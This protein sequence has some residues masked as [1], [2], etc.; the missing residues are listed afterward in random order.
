M[1]LIIFS[2]DTLVML[3][4][5]RI[6]DP[7]INPAL[8]SCVDA[9]LLT[10]LTAPFIWWFAVRPIQ[11]IADSGIHT[12]KNDL[13]QAK[14]DWEDAFNTITDMITIHD[15][16]FNIIRANTS[17]ERVLHLPLLS[18]TGP[19]CY[20]YYHGTTSPPSG[21][22]SCKSLANGKPSI[23]EVFEPH[24]NMFIEIRA[25]PRFDADKNLVGLIH[26]A[27]DISGR[28]RMEE[29][30]VNNSNR[31]KAIIETVP[32]CVK[33][34]ASDGA[35]LEM[36]RTGLSMIEAESLDQLN[37]RSIY[38][39]IAPEYR[40]SFE[41]LN[42]TVFQGGPGMLEFEMIGL[43]GTRRWVETRS[44]PLMNCKG[45][46][47]AHLG[48]T[49]DITEHKK[50]EGQLR[51]A[52]KMEA[53]GT[54]TGGIAHDFNNIL[55]AII[56]YGN[57]VK[58]KI[59]QNDPARPF[60]DQILASTERAT[61]LTQSLLA[62]SRKVAITLKPISMNETV[63]RVDELLHRLLGENV[64]LKTSFS[65]ADTTVIADSG[66]IEQVLMNLATNARDAMPDGGTVT[67][68]TDSAELDTEF[69]NT[70]GYGKKGLYTVTTV[71]DTGTGMDAH[72]RERI[73]EPFFTTKEVGKGTGLG[74]SIVYGIIKSHNGF[75]NCSSKPGRGTT[76]SI[77]LPHASASVQTQADAGTSFLP[78][79][80]SETIL[81]AEDD[82]EVRKLT[83]AFLKDFGYTIIEAEDGAGAV[84]LFVEHQDAINLLLLDAVLPGKDGKEAYDEIRNIRPGI[85]ALFMSGY[86]VSTLTE[87]GIFGDGFEFILKP[88]SPA[89]LM[90]KV[91]EV[92][93][94]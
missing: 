1:L 50:L 80:G 48:V 44:V 63:K 33:L 11:R 29:E 56:G 57:I 90:K 84:R 35:I 74:L 7:G 78:R 30:L 24:L 75:I 13:A 86:S 82:A 49:R 77:Y 3:S 41:A 61:S 89:V 53:I 4:L 83:T 76:F 31:L 5:P 62:F 36:N 43:K 71:T 58:L 64:E 37:G 39:L 27:R 28:K 51:H 65:T 70:Y 22:P 6:I 12:A 67:I 14:Q 19:K 15:K 23:V 55:T 94:K 93:D 91:R 8:A 46:I 26:V 92:L 60:I 2:V 9:T 81:L 66:Q 59:G 16:D 38:S 10:V 40:P 20:E 52:Q 73:F 17:A 87:K 47:T 79:G 32:E 88:V 25:I 72:T 85:K 54:L 45:S 68:A 18:R 69:I 34:L 21:C 42:K